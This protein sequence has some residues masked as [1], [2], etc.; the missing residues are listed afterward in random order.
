MVGIL[1]VRFPLSTLGVRYSN[2]LGWRVTAKMMQMA[3]TMITKTAEKKKQR[4]I[5]FVAEMESVSMVG[6][7]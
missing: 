3:G 1:T 2:S 6:V 7:G 4:R 5:L